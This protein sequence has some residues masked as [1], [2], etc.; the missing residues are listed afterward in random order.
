MNGSGYL[1][2]VKQTAF[3]VANQESYSLEGL[4]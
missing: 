1:A 4:N 2:D 3:M